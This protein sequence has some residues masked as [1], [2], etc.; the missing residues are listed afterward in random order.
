MQ[1]DIGVIGL[2]VMG[3]NLILNMTDHGFCV[4]AYNR[5][6]SKT[7]QFLAQHGEHRRIIGTDTLSDLVQQLHKPRK[8]LLMVSAGAAVDTLIA[9]LLPLLQTGDI[10]IDAGNSHDQNSAHRCDTLAQKGILFVGAGISGGEAG[11]R[12]GPS[13]M[14]GGNVAAWP[15]IK[16]ILQAIAAKTA[17]G[18]PCCDWIGPG[19]AGHLVKM[20]HNG[21]EYGDMQLI[22]ESYDFMHR[23]LGMDHQTMHNVYTRFN[24]TQLQSY[25]IE[26]TAHI[27][28]AKDKDGEVLLSKIRDS[29]GQKGTGKWTS[30]HALAQGVALNLITEA[31]FARFLSARKDERIHTAQ[32]L[33][34]TVNPITKH[35]STWIDDLE[36][37]LLA[38]KIISYA[39][40][41]M[42]MQ[43]TAAD[44]GWAVDCGQI[45]L[46]WREGC[47]IR[48]VLLDPIH[49]AYR[50]NP[51]LAFLGLDDYFKTI[52]QQCL[53]AW[54]RICTKAIELG[55]PMPCLNAGLQFYYSLSSAT[56]P[57]NLIQA[58][59]DYFGAHTFERI[60]A[61][62][63]Q[64][65]HHSWPSA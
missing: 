31:V 33:G 39:Q 4:A 36:H 34:L 41:F 47:I 10:I 64:F 51:S 16:P 1:A 37:A 28:L 43:Q 61:P 50:H 13:I 53:P 52:L 12:H 49:A 15:A 54:Q 58:Q 27:M 8:I 44:Q 14:P 35:Q 59:R 57:A 56:L 26:I 55:L 18:T 38:A 21:I 2:A 17:D 60:D 19:G 46:L 9:Q 11:A 32:Q 22:A 20:V 40:G 7:Q 23:A 3:Q 42:L 45:A 65:F 30:I 6:S 29:A 63:G 48:S 62:R 24:Q 5:T 25:L